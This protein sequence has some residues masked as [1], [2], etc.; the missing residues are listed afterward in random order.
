M[1]RKMKGYPLLDC[2]SDV[3]SIKHG[4]KERLISV[5]REIVKSSTR[6]TWDGM[7]VLPLTTIYTALFSSARSVGKGAN[8]PAIRLQCGETG[9]LSRRQLPRSPSPLLPSHHRAR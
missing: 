6:T 8:I 5:S 3:M 1:V 2:C 4:I 9:Y 7:G